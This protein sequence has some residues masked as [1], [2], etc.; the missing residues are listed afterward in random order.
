MARGYSREVSLACR[1]G[2]ENIANAEVGKNTTRI[3][4]SDF[5]AALSNMPPDSF[6]TVRTKGDR[7]KFFIYRNGKL[8]FLER[9]EK[10]GRDA[11]VSLRYLELFSDIDL[12]GRD[13]L[14][15]IF[16]SVE[17]QQT[18]LGQLIANF[19]EPVPGSRFRTGGGEIWLP[20]HIWEEA[21]KLEGYEPIKLEVKIPMGMRRYTRSGPVARVSAWTVG[22]GTAAL[23][24]LGT[25]GV[26]VDLG[27]VG[28][29]LFYREASQPAIA[30]GVVFGLI[31]AGISF[32]VIS[33]PENILRNA[34]DRRRLRVDRAHDQSIISEQRADE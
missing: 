13:F 28:N 2:L 30:V 19:R 31:G 4:Y 14:V 24:W 34:I 21:T 16:P 23:A 10:N 25:A 9:I 32:K 1:L 17:L 12:T 6:M 7:Q 11:L 33:L 27:P 29:G 15:S 8:L 5:Q 26:L 22:I 18:A 20:Q 3:T